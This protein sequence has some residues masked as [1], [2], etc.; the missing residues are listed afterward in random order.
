MGA[1]EAEDSDGTFRPPT[2]PAPLALHDPLNRK[3]MF[4]PD[5]Y[6][7]APCAKHSCSVSRKASIKRRWQKGLT[8]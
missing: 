3:Y 6:E 7:F 1:F 4:I 5:N 8:K 2:L